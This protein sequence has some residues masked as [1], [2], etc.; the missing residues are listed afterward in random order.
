MQYSSGEYGLFELNGKNHHRVDDRV[1]QMDS[2]LRLRCTLQNLPRLCIHSRYTVNAVPSDT[3]AILCGYGASLLSHI[4]KIKGMA[5]QVLVMATG[6]AAAAM[7]EEGVYPR[8][9]VAE[10]SWAEHFWSV[11]V[12]LDSTWLITVPEVDPVIPASVEHLVWMQSRHGEVQAVMNLLDVELPAYR[13]SMRMPKL[14]LLDAALQLGCDRIGLIGYDYCLD[15]Y[16]RFFPEQERP[17]E[18]PVVEVPGVDGRPLKAVHDMVASRE[19]FEQ[20]L[21]DLRDVYGDKMPVIFN[22]AQRGAKIEGTVWRG[23]SDFLDGATAYVSR[24]PL[25]Q[26]QNGPAVDEKNSG[27]LLEILARLRQVI[28]SFSVAEQ[29]GR[30]TLESLRQELQNM[31]GSGQ[32]LLVE[33]GR[34]LQTVADLLPDKD[35]EIMCRLGRKLS[36]ELAVDLENTMGRLFRPDQVTLRQNVHIFHSLRELGCDLIARHNP[37]LA[38]FIRGM[39]TRLPPEVRL[40]WAGQSYPTIE[41]MVQSEYVPVTQRVNRRGNAE[42]DIQRFVERNGFDPEKHGLV[43]LAPG[44]WID[45]ALLVEQ[46][47][48]LKLMIVEPWLEV[49]NAQ[50]EHNDLLSNLPAETL[51]VGMDQRLNGWAIRYSARINL[52]RAE[53]LTACFFIPAGLRRLKTVRACYSTLT[54]NMGSH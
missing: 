34:F 39:E 42:K 53:G 45:V 7:I 25:Y 1:G 11:P 16:G 13:T 19:L 26:A 3:P 28:G 44:D 47:P 21:G 37:E 2:L 36:T 4:E 31:M 35:Y 49:L 24:Y 17:D 48:T 8:V 22:C 46:F 20:G 52:W 9:I 5:E 15:A 29:R 51:I 32:V 27:V 38:G 43:L 14:L 23:M 6:R 41:Y 30:A 33:L 54:A 18:E 10:D 12:H 50:L 40:I